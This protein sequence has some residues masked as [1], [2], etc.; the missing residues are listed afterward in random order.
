MNTV[1]VGDKFEDKSYHLIQKAIENDEFG[2]SKTSARVFK[3]KGYYS[4]RREKEIIFD[5]SIEI[6]PPNA[7]RFSLLF[8]IECKSSNS[9][10]V[11]V[12]DVEEFWSKIDQVAGKNVKGVMISDNSFQKGGLNFAKNTGMML[13]EVNKENKHEIILH[14]TEKEDEKKNE[15][16]LI[17]KEFISFIRNVFGLNQI[18]GLKKLSSNYI[19][20]E[21]LNILRKYNKIKKSIDIDE[22]I[23]F[24][25]EEYDISF[26][27]TRSIESV[28]GKKIAGYYNVS[29]KEILIDCSIVNTEKFPFVLGHELGHFFLHSN[30]KINQ[31][32][33][34][35]FE[36]SKYN[37]ESDKYLLTNEKNWIEWQANKFAISLFLPRELFFIQF[38]G[39]RTRIGISK[40]QY[41]YL[42]KQKI[43]QEDYYKT[44]DYL[45][46]YFGISKTSVKYRIEDLNLIKYAEPQNNWRTILRKVVYE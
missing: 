25:N 26:D 11:P 43:N 6:W 12:D 38:V 27:F 1:K 21:A 14:R 8:L 4:Q 15:N 20:K 37:F 19:E 32:V 44:I 35:D 28:N 7:H 9:K 46:D 17:Y 31:E 10:K 33:Y 45:S 23:I 13:I 18:K 39:F 5:L 41:I 22:F 29:K 30:L 36:D 42:D 34:N 40:P 3:K 16:D 24:L 2:I